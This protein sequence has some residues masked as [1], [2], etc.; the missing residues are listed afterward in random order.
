MNRCIGCGAILQSENKDAIGY[1]PKEKEE[2]NSL[3]ERCF[4]LLHY[5]DIKWIDLPTENIVKVVNKKG[6]YAFF[7]VDLLNINEE[8][9]KTFK[10]IEIPKTLIVSKIDYIPKYVKKE[11][12]R[13]WLKEEYGILEGILFLSTVKNVN[14]HSILNTLEKVGQ[15][16]A[17]L[18]GYTNSGK[19]TLVN[20]L[21]E[22]ESVTAS[23]APNTTVDY[24][25]IPLE[26]GCSLIDS[27]GFQYKNP[28]YKNKDVSFI[29]RMNPKTFLKPITYQLK[30]DA[31]LL[32]EDVFRIENASEKCNVTIYM[33]NLLEIKKVYEKNRDLK[34]YDCLEIDVKRNEDIVI[35]GL[36][37]LNVK[38]DCH[39]KIYVE[40]KEWIGIRK[41]F[42]E[43]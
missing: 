4:R 27:P 3:C 5:N 7:L 23:L 15:K 39:L 36:G 16:E 2:L 1:I 38:T 22:K 11:K 40:N 31:S 10:E 43:R 17:Y 18:L 9:I 20:C 28:I 35:Q 29:K 32:I 30:K 12:I 8:V 19:S 33:S 41:S 24:I 26:D 21:Q 25:K 14:I 13:V 34:E 37:F 6:S 42:F